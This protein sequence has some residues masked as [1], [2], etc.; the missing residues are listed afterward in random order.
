ML[1]EEVLDYEIA[2]KNSIDYFEGDELAAKVFLDKYAL[3]DNDG[4]LLEKTP[5]EMHNRLS[6]EFARI[7]KQKFKN[8]LT[9][10]EIFKLFD[11]F[12]YMIRQG[13]PMYGIGNNY[14]TISI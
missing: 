10:E 8:P 12:R 3:R 11:K 6:K 14:Q 4:N 1:K 9:E 2:L 5:R 13:S 7:E